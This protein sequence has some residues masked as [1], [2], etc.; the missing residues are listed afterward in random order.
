MCVTWHRRH[1]FRWLIRKRA[2]WVTPC[3]SLTLWPLIKLAGLEPD[4]IKC[5][6]PVLGGSNYLH[7]LYD[8]IPS[9]FSK[10][11][12]FSSS[13]SRGWKLARRER[14]TQDEC[15]GLETSASFSSA[16]ESHRSCITSMLLALPGGNSHLFGGKLHRAFRWAGKS[17]TRSFYSSSPI[18]LFTSPDGLTVLL[19]V[20]ISK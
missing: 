14:S 9:A 20:Q 18:P 17:F 19:V 8:V 6:H 15:F 13:S 10:H 1:V 16:I 11:F 3:K 12:S 2:A 5:I 4:L 7:M